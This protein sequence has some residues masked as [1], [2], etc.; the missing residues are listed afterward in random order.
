LRAH[1]HTTYNADQGAE[2][3]AAFYFVLVAVHIFAIVVTGV[4]WTIIDL[5][6]R[7]ALRPH[8]RDIRAVHFGSLYLVPW[9]LG[10]LY[11]FER[12]QV[13][14]WHWAFFPAG[15]GLLVFCSGV[16][17]LFPRPPGLD[18]FY[19]WTRGWALVLSMIGLACLIV[20]LLWTASVLVIY[21]F[22]HG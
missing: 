16:G 2:S 7:T 14:P 18:P 15:L 13:P 3:M 4:L 5:V 17:Y 11:A 21:A 8:L 19:F 6:P 20:G 10:L 22:P 9:F 12:L 1:T